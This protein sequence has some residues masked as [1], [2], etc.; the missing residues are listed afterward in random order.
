MIDLSVLKD[1]WTEEGAREIFAQLVTHC[2]RANEPGARPIRPDP[3]DEG[4]DT[5]AGEFSTGVRVWQAKYFMSGIGQSQQAQI[6]DSWKTCIESSYAKRLVS[7]TLCIPCELSIDEQKW[8][9]QWKA[10]EL[11]KQKVPMDIWTRT[12]FTGFSVRKGLSPIFACALSRSGEFATVADVIS[13]MGKCVRRVIQRLPDEHSAALLRAVFVRKLEAA[14]I[15]NHRAARVA[16]YNFELARKSIEEGGTADE[17]AALQDLQERT[18]DLWEWLFNQ[19]CPEHLGRAL[20]TAVQNEMKAQDTQRL[21]TW[22]NLDL[23]HKKGGLH[24]W[25][26]ICEAGWTHDHASIIEKEES[27][28]SESSTK[29][30]QGKPE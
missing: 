12:M 19:H 1:K 22:L 23:I 7:W 30:P 6:R 13:A 16:F 29:T 10:K 18:Y 17:F 2:V 26:D 15:T 20:Y 24:Y 11:K 5:F 21:A 25:T 8:W 9:E 14:G 28:A 3:G 27:A 4:V